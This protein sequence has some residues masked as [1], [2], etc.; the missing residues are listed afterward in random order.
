MLP[1]NEFL[2]QVNENENDEHVV[3]LSKIAVYFHV[4]ETSVVARGKELG[5]FD[6]L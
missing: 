5:I 2:H 6:I 3:N 4:D 1:S